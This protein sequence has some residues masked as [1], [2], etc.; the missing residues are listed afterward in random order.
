M[1]E[2]AFR[3]AVLELVVLPD[4]RWQIESGP[5]LELT[6]I[7]HAVVF[8]FAVWS[9]PAHVILRAYSK[10]LASLY[11]IDVP[12]IIVDID[13][14]QVASTE[15]F[16]PYLPHGVG[17]TYFVKEGAIIESITTLLLR[18][19]KTVSKVPQTIDISANVRRFSDFYEKVF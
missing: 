5:I 13:S 6:K 19:R 9:G 16:P 18:E 14:I 12:L 17:E 15:S 3:K 7:K 8:V 2:S 1:D 10:A 11:P 4:E